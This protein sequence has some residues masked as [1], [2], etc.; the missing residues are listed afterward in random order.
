MTFHF[1]QLW[2]SSLGTRS[3]F[4]CVLGQSCVFPVHMS[5]DPNVGQ[6]DVSDTKFEL[7]SGQDDR[8]RLLV[9]Q[10]NTTVLE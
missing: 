7:L 6:K 4:S 5:R 9:S 10:L 2:E 8:E 3:P 1:Y